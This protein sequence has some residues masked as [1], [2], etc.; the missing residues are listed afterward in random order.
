MFP[1]IFAFAADGPH[2]ILY[3]PTHKGSR[4]IIHNYVY[5]FIP[6]LK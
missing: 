5:L 2:P 3:S 6:L 4:H 1:R